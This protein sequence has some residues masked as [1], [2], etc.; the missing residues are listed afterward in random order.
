MTPVVG[1]DGT[2]FVTEW[3]PGGDESDHIV[4]DSFEEMT[5]RYDANKNNQLERSEMPAGPLASR[6]DQIDRNKDGHITAREYEWA[7]NIFNSAQ[8]ATLAISPGARG[9]ATD[10]HVRLA[11]REEPA[12]HPLARLRRRPALHGQE[13][14]DRVL[15]RRDQRTAAQAK[16]GA[17]AHDYYS[18]PVVGDG[19]L[20]V[21]DVEGGATMFSAT[22]ELKVISTA[23][24]D[25]PT[26]ATPAL[27]DGRI[28]L[29]TSKRLYCFGNSR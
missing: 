6:F 3:T 20:L 18:S 16:A 19:K 8:N 12:L 23:D 5:A 4:A 29:R 28:Y 27:V 2:L 21:V 24:F 7:R 11:L 14:R 1:S 17:G 10:S 15:R 25:E 13:R 22:P 9:E 26:Y